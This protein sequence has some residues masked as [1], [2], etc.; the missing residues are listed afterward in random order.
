M[1]TVSDQQ[2][3]AEAEWLEAW[4]KGSDVDCV[5]SDPSSNRRTGAGPKPSRHEG[6]HAPSQ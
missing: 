6:A 4:L 1:S 3:A 5:D 2:Q